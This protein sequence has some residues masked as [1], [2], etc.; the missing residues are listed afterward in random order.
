MPDYLKQND[1]DRNYRSLAA[2][3]LQKYRVVRGESDLWIL[4]SHDIRAEVKHLL[5]LYRRELKE[6]IFKYPVFLTTLE[7]YPVN[8]RSPEL[9][10]RMS[11]AGAKAGVGPM[12]SVAGAIAGL[13]GEN[14]RSEVSD[15]IIENGGDIYLRST[16]ERRIAI[17]AGNSPFSM[18]IALEIPPNPDGIGICTSAGTVGPSLSFGTAD[19]T[20]II[21]ADVALADATATAAGNLIS[22]TADLESAIDFV[23]SIPDVSGVLLIKDDKMAAWGEIKLIPL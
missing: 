14:I 12:A 3:D 6:F 2:T 18:K 20:V 17:Y 13:I 19:A 5:T 16:R 8:P 21:S 7:P 1:V 9:V 22:K 15:L 4:S 23:K 11:V 10:R